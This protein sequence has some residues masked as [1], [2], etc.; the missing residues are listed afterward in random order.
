MKTNPFKYGGVVSDPYFIDRD[1][2]TKE[3]TSSLQASQNVILYSPRRYGK[4]SLILKVAS[5]L[6]K[7]GVTVVYFDLFHAN[8]QDRFLELYYQAVLK[9]V[10]SWEKILR[11]VSE[12]VKAARPV[13]VMEQSGL[14]SVTLDFDRR[15]RSQY[16]EEVVNLPEK[17]AGKDHW[18]VIF[19][20]FQEIGRLDGTN[21]EKELRAVI[22]H[23]KKVNY[24]LMGS[25]KHLLLGMVTRRDRAFYNFGKLVH[26]G[27]ID[28]QEW[29]DYISRGMS[30]SA[31]R[32][33]EELIRE[34]IRI[35][36]NIPFYVQYLASEVWETSVSGGLFDRENLN[37]AVTR[38]LNNQADYYMTLWASLSILQQNTLRAL[39]I[40]NVRVFSK[41]FIAKHRLGTASGIQRAISVLM[42]NGII[43]LH[44]GI[45]SFEDP[46][47]KQWL[48]EQ[49]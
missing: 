9:S 48:V 12:L 10:P 11:T 3:L 16:F 42:N 8:S 44:S 41:D 34:I 35:S 17:L 49:Q 46:F 13:V 20:E 14:P 21:F 39:S 15:R 33:D 37:T 26:L 45:Y 28:A 38:L 27:K 43:D 18:V 6:K 30:N 22:Q 23:H 31:I 19:D 36:E 24:V 25:K 2:E 32:Y 40:D 5:E 29:V 4:T 7:Q 1:E 47:F